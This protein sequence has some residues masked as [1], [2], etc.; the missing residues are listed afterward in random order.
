M[1]EWLKDLRGSKTQ[2]EVADKA[3]IVESYYSMIETNTRRPPVDTAK[4]I[5]RALNFD[6]HLFYDDTPPP[7]QSQLTTAAE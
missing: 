5:A 3:G 2:K 1:R 7:H 4:A 6:W